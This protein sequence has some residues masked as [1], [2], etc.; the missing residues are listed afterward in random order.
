[1][2]KKADSY[3]ENYQKLKQIAEKMRDQ[4]EPDIDQLVAMVNEATKAYKNC[5]AR[6]ESVEKAL[7]FKN[8]E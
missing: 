1:M 3:Q 6:I 8:E 5:Q 7:G 2:S 4:E